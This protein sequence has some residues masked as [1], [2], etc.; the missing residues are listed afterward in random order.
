MFEWILS[1]DDEEWFIEFHR[2]I[3]DRYLMLLHGFEECRLDF[4]WRTID[5]ICEEDMGEYRSFSLR[6]NSLLSIIDLS[7]DEV[8]REQIRSEGYPFE[9]E[10][11]DIGKCLHSECFSESRNSLEED[12]PSGKKGDKYPP[13][14]Q[15]LSDDRLMDSIFE[16]DNRLANVSESR[17]Q[18]NE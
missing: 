6:K 5:L 17:I 4:R 14:K 9:V 10:C 8:H 13:N 3:S 7:P 12:M 15:I 16:C 18:N 11:E 1:R 2:L